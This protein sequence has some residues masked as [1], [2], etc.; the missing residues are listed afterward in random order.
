M[1]AAVSMGAL[2]PLPV[3]QQPPSD[4][5]ASNR[6][7]QGVFMKSTVQHNEL[8][9]PTSLSQVCFFDARGTADSGIA[10]RTRASVPLIAEPLDWPAGQLGASLVWH[11]LCRLGLSRGPPGGR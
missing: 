7:A 10:R 2:Q 8:G 9:A 5:V 11:P 3:R 1:V 4:R 6:T